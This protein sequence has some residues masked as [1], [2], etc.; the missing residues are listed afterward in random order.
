[1]IPMPLWN[2]IPTCPDPMSCYTLVALC[3]IVTVSGG[4]VT[5]AYWWTA[6]EFRCLKDEIKGHDNYIE[7]TTDII[8]KIQIELAVQESSMKTL[9]ADIAEIKTDVK[10]LLTR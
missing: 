6:K 10:T 2:I 9:K 7:D 1:M 3:A 5:L 8:N 4:V